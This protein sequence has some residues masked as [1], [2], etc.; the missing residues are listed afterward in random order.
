MRLGTEAG[1]RR[2]AAPG[3]CR[4]R[5]PDVGACPLCSSR[6]AGCWRSAACARERERP[7][8]ARHGANV[9]A[10]HRDTVSPQ[11]TSRCAPLTTGVGPHE[12]RRCPFCQR[13]A[14]RAHENVVAHD[15]VR[16]LAVKRLFP[17]PPCP[18]VPVPRPVCRCPCARVPCA[19]VPCAPVRVCRCPCARVPCSRVPCRVPL[20]RVRLCPC[21]PMFPKPSRPPLG[22]SGFWL[23]STVAPVAGS[24]AARRRSPTG[25]LA[26]AACCRGPVRCRSS[27]GRRTVIRAPGKANWGV[28][29]WVRP[30]H[31]VERAVS[32][33]NLRRRSR[34]HVR[35][36][37][38]RSVG[39]SRM[40]PHRLGPGPKVPI[41]G[42]RSMT[43]Y[44]PSDRAAMAGADVMRGH[45]GLV[46][47]PAR[48]LQVSAES[49]GVGPG[50]A[51]LRAA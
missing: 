30:C 15:A 33:A 40:A 46:H 23:K 41:N 29:G 16:E 47:R 35:R 25:E 2:R 45:G 31:G 5:A 3:A 8:A 27:G 11:P 4:G 43:R 50:I 10:R 48:V 12:R 22:I 26:V 21:A 39:A 49:F 34:P 9:S 14:A 19:P 42:P 37:L 32:T 20:C 18:C 1:V 51:Q 6:E 17:V 24:V 38:S 7:G 44:Q 28:A 13:A 36:V